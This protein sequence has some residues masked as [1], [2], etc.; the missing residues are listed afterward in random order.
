M[1]ISVP[2][3]LVP[4]MAGYL[5]AVEWYASLRGL[6]PNTYTAT[7]AGTYDARV[8]RDAAAYW[9]NWSPKPVQVILQTTTVTPPITV[10]GVM[11]TVLPD[12][13]GDTSVILTLPGGDSL[14]TWK[15]LSTGATVGTSQTL[16]VGASK[17]GDYIAAIIPF[18]GCSS[19]YSPAFPVVKATGPNPPPAASNLVTTALSF[20]KVRL[21]WA[22]NPNPTY[23]ATAYEIYRGTKTGVYK[24]VGAA[25]YDS[26]AFTDSLSVTAGVKYY[27]AIRA[28]DTT[29]AAPLSNVSVVTTQS[30]VTPPTAPGNLTVVAATNAS[31]TLGWTASTDNVG[32]DHYAVYT[33][34]VLSNV[35]PNLSFL[36]NGLTKGKLYSFY[37]KAVDASGNYSNQ[38]GQVDAPALASGLNYSYYTTPVGWS[39]LPN[40]STLT[41]TMSGNMPAVSIANATQTINFG[42]IWTGYINIPVAGTYKF[43]TSSDDG[44]ALWFNTLTPTGTPTVNN[45]GLHGTTAVN[46]AAIVLQPGVYPICIEYFQNG[47][48]SAMTASWSSTQLFG[49]SNFV[50]IA[51]KYFAANYTPAGTAP[52][53]PTQ[54]LSSAIAYNK[55]NVSWVDNS[56]NETG[57]EVYRAISLGGPYQIVKTA[58]A[59]ATSMVDSLGLASSTKYYYKVQAV[60]QYGGSGYDSA[61]MGGLTY[62]FY[63]GAFSPLPNFDS[64]PVVPV[65]SSGTL[66]N[67][68]LAPAGSVTTNFGF[69]FSGTI[70]IPVTGTYTFYTSSDDASELFINGYNYAHMV[71]NNNFQQ[72]M[73]QRSGTITLAKGSYPFYVAYE[74][75]GGGFGLTVSWANTAGGIPFSAIPDSVFYNKNSS[76][77]TFALPAAPVTPYSIVDSA[78]SASKVFLSWTDTSSAIT[79][80]NLSR[81]IGDSSHFN[82]LATLAPGTTSFNDSSLFGHQTYYYEL[83]ATGPGGTSASTAAIAL[84]TK[85][86]PPVF[87]A[88]PT[89]YVRY[90]STKAFPVSVTDA[91]GDTLALSVTNLPSFGTLTN[92]G[93]GKATLSF[94]PTSQGTYPGIVLSANDNHG[95]IV[96]DTFTLVVNNDYPPVFNTITNVTLNANS[97]LNIPI[98]ATDSNA[99]DTLSFTVT[100]LPAN[101]TLAA[102]PNGSDTIKLHP[103]FGDGGVYTVVATVNDNNGGVTSDTF[104]ITVVKVNPTQQVDVSV[105]RRRCGRCAVECDAKQRHRYGFQGYQ[106]QSHNHHRPELPARLVDDL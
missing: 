58:P 57:F 12:A 63:Q 71:V 10:S 55:V 38:S 29:G 37:V 73:T 35:T 46:S 50:P 20:T 103:N 11:S 89:E 6:R 19:F 88:L 21:T 76:T 34:G 59:S 85:D 14:Y 82:I 18:Q 39:V 47:G 45:D 8:M 53:K 44:S 67:V 62:N 69:L 81:S 93:N 68:S 87:T 80:Y 65:V 78:I 49:N 92:T 40:F 25:A 101:S 4:G 95:A 26:L 86:N 7:Q 104:H 66:T 13:A 97:T 48:G 17:T 22:T 61:S 43:Q 31:I 77:T 23:P 64:I 33:N 106:W 99:T 84:V 16:K 36:V 83:T 42:Y 41:P 5:V 32:V 72:G 60:N 51:S 74:Q 105:Q 15:M 98:S 96:S 75:S 1:T 102:G 3:G 28:V 90:N 54:I 27:Y 79:S 24:Y 2:M 100:G 30:D 70:N 56:N 94:S 52:A 9:S 91:D